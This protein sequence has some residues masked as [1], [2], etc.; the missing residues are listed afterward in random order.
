VYEYGVS[1]P[2][3]D[4]RWRL[5]TPTRLPDLRFRNENGERIWTTLGMSTAAD[6]A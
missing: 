3:P 5:E 1:V 4:S 2:D 6:A